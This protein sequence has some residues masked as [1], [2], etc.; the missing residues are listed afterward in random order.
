MRA[1]ID[2]TGVPGWWSKKV[3]SPLICTVGV[4]EGHG[5]VMNHTNTHT[6]QPT[7]N[8]LNNHSVCLQQWAGSRWWRLRSLFLQK[9][10]IVHNS[11]ESRDNELA[12]YRV[13]G[14]Q[15]R[16]RSYRSTQC[17]R[18]YGHD[19][20]SDFNNKSKTHRWHKVQFKTV[21]NLWSQWDRNP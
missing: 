21:I 8:T 5:S 19:S 13:L 3:V 6:Q 11:E 4:G 18:Q 15:S 17:T 16:F 7:L 20:P 9:Y 1:S 2:H 10:S 12:W 14:V